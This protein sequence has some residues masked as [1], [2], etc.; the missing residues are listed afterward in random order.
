M[1]ALVFPAIAGV[2]GGK[3]PAEREVRVDGRLL[4]LGAK[5]PHQTLGAIRHLLERESIVKTALRTSLPH[6]ARWLEGEL[7]HLLAPILDLRN[8]AAH[9]EPVPFE[10]I[11]RL[12]RDVLGI[13]C[14]GLLVRIAR[15]KIRAGK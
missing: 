10:R 5:V 15:A 12:R 14:E 8:P 13:G 1:N 4:D 6:D 11:D 7:P 2:V 3:R 9:K